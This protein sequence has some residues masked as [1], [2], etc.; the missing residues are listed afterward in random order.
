MRGWIRLV[1]TAIAQG[2][3]EQVRNRILT[4]AFWG[5]AATASAAAEPVPLELVLA[6]DVSTSVDA[7]EFALQQFGTAQAFRDPAVVQAIEAT[8]G[9]AVSVVQWAGDGEVRVAVPWSRLETAEDAAVFADAIA[10]M[11]RMVRGFTF[12]DGAIRFAAGQIEQNDFS[13]ADRKSVV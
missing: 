12:I 5:I 3:M 9:L 1:L 11:P 8:G 10:I 13:G 2:L 4:A 6:M 7:E